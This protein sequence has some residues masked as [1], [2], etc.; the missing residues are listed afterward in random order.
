MKSFLVVLSVL[1]AL[2]FLSCRTQTLA[3]DTGTA[4]IKGQVILSTDYYHQTPPF[5]GI[6]VSIEGT[7]YSAMTDS[8]GHYELD[9]VPG[10][11]YDVHFSKPGY[12]DIRWFGM[13]VQGG[14]TSPVYWYDYQPWHNVVFPTLFK[15]PDFVTTL[16]SVSLDDSLSGYSNM[17]I[18]MLHGS[19]SGS[20]QPDLLS[21]VIYFSH[22]ANLSSKP[23]EYEWLEPWTTGS[24]CSWDTLNHTFA[25]PVGLSEYRNHGFAS[26]D[27]VYFATYG[28]PAWGTGY[29][30]SDYYDPVHGVPVISS[31]N[32]TPSPVIGI[33]V[34]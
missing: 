21:I 10:G 22:H 31:L 5:S 32:Q 20:S 4:T 17:K 13:Q 25:L 18:V 27:S 34:P 9:D 24:M 7:G 8:G 23:G 26:G 28:G 19:F 12:G 33:K 6:Q 15:Q 30:Y 11:T 29:P 14:G 16:R 1:V 2:S 3:P